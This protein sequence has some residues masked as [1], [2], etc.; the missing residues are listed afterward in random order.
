MLRGI[1]NAHI[2][3]WLVE[4]D[5]VGPCWAIPFSFISLLYS[6]VILSCLAKESGGMK[7]GANIFLALNGASA[8]V[9]SHF[10]VAKSMKGWILITLTRLI[11]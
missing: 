7:T 9:F 4:D 10:S 6:Q 1:P 5:A 8:S 3:S 11:L 2:G